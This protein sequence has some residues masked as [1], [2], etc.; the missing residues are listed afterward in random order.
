MDMIV[1]VDEMPQVGETIISEN[2]KLAHGGKG[3]NQAVAAKRMGNE[4]HMISKIGKDAY[5]YEI[6]ESLK[7][8]NIDVSKVFQD[9]CKPTGTA[10]ITVNKDGNN[11][12]IVIPGANMAI[13]KYEI[14]SCKDIII[15]SDIVVAQFET[16]LDATIEAF[17]IAKE[18]DVITI[19]NPAPANKIPDELLKYT[20]IIIPNETE[21]ATLTGIEVTN[22]ED[23]EKAA[24]SFL[25]KGVKYSIITLG[26]KGAALVSNERS[27]IVPAYKVKAVDTTA[28]GDSFI[29]ALSAKLD[30][31]NVNFDTLIEAVKF[32]NKV[33]SIVVQKE[34]AQ[35]SIPFINDIENI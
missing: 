7:N 9:K 3:A 14:E 27:V 33:S 20:D 15:N 29:G 12:I 19:L 23:A 16:T 28:A 35:P 25:S 30:K 26:E 13:D 18:N 11:S 8:E 21:A 24:K 32:G 5:G 10:I 6:L 34:G 1:S 17:K 4:V 31:K 22:L 2:F